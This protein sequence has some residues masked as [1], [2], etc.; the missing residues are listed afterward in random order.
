MNTTQVRNLN[1]RLRGLIREC[2]SLA[3]DLGVTLYVH[4]FTSNGKWGYRLAYFGNGFSGLIAEY[5]TD[6]SYGYVRPC[7]S[8]THGLIGRTLANH[9]HE[10]GNVMGLAVAFHTYNIPLSIYS[11]QPQR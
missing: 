2:R 11:Y 9:L 1:A 5:M 8:E 3:L 10:T 6:G 4:R 7:E